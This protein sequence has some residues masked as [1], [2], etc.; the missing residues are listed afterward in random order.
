M[1][2]LKELKTGFIFVS[3]LKFGELLCKILVK[4]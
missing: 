2:V 1:L 3:D 4:K